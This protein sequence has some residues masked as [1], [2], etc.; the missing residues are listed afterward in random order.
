MRLK[1]MQAKCEALKRD[2]HNKMYLSWIFMKNLTLKKLVNEIS[3]P[4]SRNIKEDIFMILL[5][6]FQFFPSWN[7]KYR[8]RSNLILC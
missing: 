6:N 2:L 5:H 4:D 1:I 3:Y 8:M 7:F